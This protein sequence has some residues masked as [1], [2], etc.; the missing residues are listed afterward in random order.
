MSK[1]EV[2]RLVNRATTMSDQS[3]LEVIE[4]GMRLLL[5]W[6]GD[7]PDWPTKAKVKLGSE[8][9]EAVSPVEVLR[10]AHDFARNGGF[11]LDDLLGAIYGPEVFVWEAKAV[12]NRIASL[13][14]A[15]GYVSKQKR[16]DGK[17]VLAWGLPA[18]LQ[19]QIVVAR[20]G[21]R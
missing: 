21:V 1:G 19:H 13:L 9:N 15:S 14:R 11:T 10:H 20:E 16:K 2:Q 8:D 18:G 5:A 12:K 7:N 6:Y 4:Q 17:R 3:S